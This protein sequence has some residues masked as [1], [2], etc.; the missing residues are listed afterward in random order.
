M[1]THSALPYEVSRGGGKLHKIERGVGKRN[2]RREKKWAR[3][4][5]EL[6]KCSGAQDEGSRDPR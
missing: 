6:I 5:K 2:G 1:S 3:K 4:A